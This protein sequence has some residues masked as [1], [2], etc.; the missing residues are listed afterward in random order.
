MTDSPSEP[1]AAPASDRSTAPPTPRWVKISGA[2]ALAVVVVFLVLHLTGTGMG[3][4][5]HGGH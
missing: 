5:M 2:V 3:P 4:G 1:A